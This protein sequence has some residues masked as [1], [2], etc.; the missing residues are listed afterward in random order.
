MMQREDSNQCKIKASLQV[1][2]GSK[3]TND[4]EN[5]T[6][7]SYVSDPEA[8]KILTD[9]LDAQEHRQQQD[10]EAEDQRRAAMTDEERTRYD[11]LMRKAAED[12][13][14]GLDL[15]SSELYSKV[16][17]EKLAAV[18]DGLSLA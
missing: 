17:K 4:M 16:I 7:V 14:A 6:I 5:P 3:S 10:K 2:G 1:R 13:A 8:R 9:F 18:S 11:A 15:E 12:I